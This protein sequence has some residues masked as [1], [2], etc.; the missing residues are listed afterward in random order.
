MLCEILERFRATQDVDYFQW[1][2]H[3][4]VCIFHDSSTSLG[5]SQHSRAQ[6]VNRLSKLFLF[7]GAVPSLKV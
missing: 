4:Q 6:T 7:L 1:V 2:S 3:S 5:P